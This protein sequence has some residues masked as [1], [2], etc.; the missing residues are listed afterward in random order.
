MA[1]NIQIIIY[2]FLPFLSLSFFRKLF[3]LYQSTQHCCRLERI[4]NVQI[5]DF[6]GR[7]KS[8]IQ[9][10]TEKRIR[11]ISLQ[12]TTRHKFRTIDKVTSVYFSSFFYVDKKEE[13]SN[14][15]ECA[16]GYV[17]AYRDLPSI[18]LKWRAVKPCQTK[19]KLW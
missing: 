8:A 2:D 6:N 17:I 1:S 15:L 10:G 19:W 11:K 7:L 12:H 9:I 3:F 14:H 18:R 16:Y 4:Q 5:P 13:E